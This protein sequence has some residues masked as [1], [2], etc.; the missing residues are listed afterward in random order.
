LAMYSNPESKSTKTLGFRA[1][2]FS[3]AS[4]NACAVL[5]SNLPC[6]VILVIWLLVSLV[7]FN[8]IGLSS[9]VRVLGVGGTYAP[10]Q[11]QT[12]SICQLRSKPLFPPTRCDTDPKGLVPDRAPKSLPELRPL[13]LQIRATP[14]LGEGG[15]SQIPVLPSRYSWPH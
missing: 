11:S 8:V 7:M 2:A 5:A 14:P 13:C 4:L 15:E 9:S 3:I 6:R 12:P 1:A 10:I